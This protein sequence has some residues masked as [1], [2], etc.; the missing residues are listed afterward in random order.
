MEELRAWATSEDEGE[1]GAHLL[2][3]SL[4]DDG[5]T[6]IDGT[7]AEGVED[8]DEWFADEGTGDASEVKSS[9]TTLIPPPV[10]LQ[11]SPEIENYPDAGADFGAGKSFF[12]SLEERQPEEWAAARDRNPYWPFRDLEEWELALWLAE[13]DLPVERISSFLGL[14]YVSAFETDL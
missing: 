13:S 3:G 5:E 11:T 14:G 10:T 7:S 1:N 9:Q 12:C 8:V 4:M 6:E 2:E